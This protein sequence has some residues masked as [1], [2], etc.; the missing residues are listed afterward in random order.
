MI[1][2]AR[3]FGAP[4]TVPAGKHARNTSSA[5]RPSRSRPSTWLTRCITCEYRSTT[6]RSGTVTDAVL[7]HA[8]HVVA[9]EIHQHAVLGELLLVRQQVLGEAR[10]S[11]AVLPRG[12][13]PAMGRT[14]TVSSSTRTST[15]GEL[16]TSDIPSSSRKY[17][18]GD[19]FRLRSAR[20]RSNG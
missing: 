17:R 3:T 1:S 19:G 13:V 4:E 6:M 15:S 14:V 9:A 10:S 16:P 11:S 2:M 8:S 7:G 18:Y 12:R 5:P 20:Y